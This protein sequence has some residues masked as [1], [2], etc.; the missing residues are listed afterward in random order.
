MSPRRFPGRG[1]MIVAGLTTAAAVVAPTPASA[2]PIDW[3]LTTGSYSRSWTNPAANPGYTAVEVAVSNR[4]DTGACAPV[5]VEL[6]GPSG[7][8]GAQTTTCPAPSYPH[9]NTSGAG[10]YYFYLGSP[11]GV[12]VRA[13]GRIY[14]PGMS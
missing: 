7:S 3:N 9:W 4:A 13:S 2:A 14:Y 10:V 11:T 5:T 12:S 8:Y 1:A 6:Y